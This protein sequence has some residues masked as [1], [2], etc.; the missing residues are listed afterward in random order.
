[1]SL[2]ESGIAIIRVKSM[3]VFRFAGVLFGI[4]NC[5]S[6]IPG[7]IAPEVAG[8]LTPNVRCCFVVVVVVVICLFVSLVGW[9]VGCVFLLLFC[10]VF[11]F[12]FVFFCLGFVVVVV[13]LFLLLLV[14]CWYGLSSSSFFLLFCLFVFISFHFSTFFKTNFRCDKSSKSMTTHLV[15]VLVFFF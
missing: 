13:V 10:F 8:A 12:C 4:T 3:P 2:A 11:C 14:L 1:M 15:S 5:V 9:L 7:I 6:T